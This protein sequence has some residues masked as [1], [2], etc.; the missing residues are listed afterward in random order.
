MSDN[1]I[2]VNTNLEKENNIKLNKAIEE[3]YKLK[4]VYED[5]F[6]QQYVKPILKQKEFSIK[7]KRSKYQKLP[8]PKCINCK[9]NVGTIFQIKGSDKYIN[10][11][12]IAHCGDT[13]NPCPLDI[14]ISMSNVQLIDDIL[15]ENESSVGSINITKKK[16]IKAKNDLL[17]GY[18]KEDKAFQ[19]FEELTKE[20]ETETKRYEYFLEQ[21]ILTYD[22][23][24]KKEILK[25]EKTELGINIQQFKMM[26]SEFNKTNNVQIVYNAVEM[27]INEIEPKLKKI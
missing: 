5:N 23:P 11:V 24:E 6:Y 17:F 10:H 3:Y 1:E 8:K 20:L 4:N 12:Y 19:I 22:N 25:K 16:I 27:F 14:K 26:I 21:F 18:L 9:R 7:E 2:E 13:S 15:L